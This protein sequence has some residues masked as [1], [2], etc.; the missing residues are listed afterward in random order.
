M[1]GAVTRRGLFGLAVGAFLT[2]LRPGNTL[3]LRFQA[4]FPIGDLICDD[5]TRADTLHMQRHLV[6]PFVQTPANYQLV[7]WEGEED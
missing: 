2:A 4:S 7:N 3:P 1:G 6:L 5:G